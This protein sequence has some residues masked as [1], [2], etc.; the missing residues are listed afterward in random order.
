[1]IGILLFLIA[2]IALPQSVFGRNDS[3]VVNRLLSGFDIKIPGPIKAGGAT[4]KDI[5]VKDLKLG[6][7]DLDFTK[8]GI[9]SNTSLLA[10]KLN[11][12]GVYGSLHFHDVI[13]GSADVTIETSGLIEVDFSLKS[14]EPGGVPF[15]IGVTKL[16]I[17]LGKFKCSDHVVWKGNCKDLILKIIGKVEKS[18]STMDS[19]AK[20]VQP[21]ITDLYD[22]SHYQQPDSAKDIAREWEETYQYIQ[23]ASDLYNFANSS[24]FDVIALVVNTVYGEID[25]MTGKTGLTVL[26]DRFLP[27]TFP[28]S[29]TIY[30]KGGQHVALSNVTIGRANVSS[31]VLRPVGKFTFQLTMDIP[32][33]E[34]D[35]YA[36]TDLTSFDK[37]YNYSEVSEFSVTTS[38]SI[39]MTFSAVV[40]K[41]QF[42]RL[43][44]GDLHFTKLIDILSD[45][46]CWI[47]HP[48]LAWDLTSLFVDIE[49]DGLI[50]KADQFISKDAEKL[51][52]EADGIVNDLYIPT[53]EAFIA[54][55][56]SVKL[57]NL[58]NE[59]LHIPKINQT[60]PNPCIGKEPKLKFKHPDVWYNESLFVGLVDYIVN[61]FIGC[62]DAAGIN[63]YLKVL[64]DLIPPIN[65]T[66]SVTSNKYF[67]TIGWELTN[68][69]IKADTITDMDVLLPNET[70]P[71]Q[72]DQRLSMDTF[73]VSID[74]FFFV[75]GTHQVYFSDNMTIWFELNSFD[76]LSSIEASLNNTRL[77]EPE[78]NS[79]STDGCTV[80]TLDSLQ[81]PWTEMFIKSFKMNVECK[82]NQCMSPLFYQI[83]SKMTSKEGVKQM[84]EGV[85]FFL[86]QINNILN[87]N[88]TK[89]FFS[90]KTDN[91]RILC[92]TGVEPPP[93]SYGGGKS[94]PMTN[95]KAYTIVWGVSGSVALILTVYSIIT[96][97]K[98]RKER[99]EED[100]ENFLWK[101]SELPL[102]L[103]PSMS[104]YVR[105]GVLI[106]LLGTLAM[107]FSSNL[108]PIGIGAIVHAIADVGGS[109][110]QIEN[111]FVYALA[112]TIRDMWNGE[113]YPLSILVCVLSG[114]W[115]YSKMAGLI[116]SWIVPPCV[117]G[118]ER[119]EL[120]LR[121][122]DFFG[123]WSLIDT[124]MVVMMM[125]AFR[126]HIV[127]PEYWAF[128]PEDLIVLDI[129][130][131][132]FWGLF[133]FM[134]AAI[135]SLTLNHYMVLAHRNSVEYDETGGAVGGW[136]QAV[137][138]EFENQKEVLATHSV[139]GEEAKVTRRR[140]TMLVASLILSLTLLIWGTVEDT[141]KFEFE[142]L[143]AYALDIDNPGSE[144][145]S[146]SLLALAKKVLDQIDIN[147]GQP[148]FEFWYLVI[149]FVIFTFVMPV[150]QVI[151]LLILWFIPMTLTQQKIMFFVNE[152]IS[153]WCALEVFVVV[154]IAAL[155]EISKLAQFLIGSNCDAINYYMKEAIHPLGFLTNYKATC[156]D[157]KATLSKGC[158]L[159]FAACVV[160]NIVYIRAWKTA[161]EVIKARHHHQEALSP[162]NV[163]GQESG[164]KKLGDGINDDGE[165]EE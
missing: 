126:L 20:L 97:R 62:Q 66:G 132:P 18:Q 32:H 36:H 44:L 141:F 93:S 88:V 51:V 19:I 156:F 80:G 25:D 148:P 38:L 149:G 146:Y 26:L 1:M 120:V 29:A 48:V 136:F 76:I 118:H 124:L 11:E 99:I 123:K 109:K 128:I 154:L 23:P 92:D 60:T 65:V 28:V 16:S 84:T 39:D 134:N 57:V 69:Q 125:V 3:S 64:G 163:Q 133:G 106:G 55:E 112:N 116:W 21:Y 131:T 17:D 90:T 7:V 6:D 119:R 164:F 102:I 145:S 83:P 47:D 42:S 53:L 70:N 121:V 151:G 34:M 85:V 129:V 107:F 24:A 27:L 117:I 89:Q 56:T 77:L 159:L 137:D 63:S 158:W 2:A 101:S 73:R 37:T 138:P 33:I 94:G 144:T 43:H 113:V 10:V 74:V 108:P 54:N 31:L 61:D 111:V 35:L 103:H 91:E 67:G 52:S 147:S 8:Q 143:A 50:V 13:G 82:E 115:P 68:L 79:F 122:L 86:D 135:L 152:V 41:T 130:V 9:D 104:P 98:W 114:I 96:F 95:W 165:D 45:L 78:L 105:F 15:E 139:Y 72:L 49:E 30:D 4:L 142:G 46:E 14:H 140:A 58:V 87:N 71:T 127:T 162:L 157:V 100:G 22:L 153:A 59:V 75:G 5:E 81:F 110:V 161:E 12:V 155:L 160:S 150:L 40:N